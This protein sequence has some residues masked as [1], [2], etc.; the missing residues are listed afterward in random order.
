[1]PLWLRFIIHITAYVQ[2]TAQEGQDCTGTDYSYM[3]QQRP[4]VN[5][6][7]R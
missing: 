5:L 4:S 3:G 7:M 2:H 1:M 6:Y